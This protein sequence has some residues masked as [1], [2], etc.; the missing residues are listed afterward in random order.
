MIIIVYVF[1]YD[2]LSVHICDLILK[3]MLYSLHSLRGKLVLLFKTTDNNN[4]SH[5]LKVRGGGGNG[6]NQE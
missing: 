3:F 2:L 1:T 6:E 5:M 4:D